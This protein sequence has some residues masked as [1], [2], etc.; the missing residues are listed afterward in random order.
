MSDGSTSTVS[1]HF[2]DDI[3]GVNDIVSDTVE[4]ESVSDQAY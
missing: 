4:S 3:G 2:Y 1:G